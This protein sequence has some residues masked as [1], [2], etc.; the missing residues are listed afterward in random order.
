MAER[1]EAIQQ[2]MEEIGRSMRRTIRKYLAIGPEPS[3]LPPPGD[4]LYELNL[5]LH[6]FIA[7]QRRRPCACGCCGE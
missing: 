6:Q 7:H 2:A 5:R 1:D 4:P 3:P